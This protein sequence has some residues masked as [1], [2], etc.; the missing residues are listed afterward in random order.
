MTV[1]ANGTFDI[2]WGFDPYRFQ[3]LIL[4]EAATRIYYAAD[5]HKNKL[6]LPGRQSVKAG[7]IGNLAIKSID[8]N[9]VW[10]TVFENPGIDFVF[11]GNMSAV[12]GD[13]IWKHNF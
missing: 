11:V 4:F 8:K 13:E 7:Y 3:D 5:W 9:L 6:P 2:V 1:L 12:H 10:Q